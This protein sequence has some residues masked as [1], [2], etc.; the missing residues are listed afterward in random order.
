MNSNLDFSNLVTFTKQFW[1]CCNFEF[2]LKFWFVRTTYVTVANIYL[3]NFVSRNIVTITVNFVYYEQL[4]IPHK[5]AITLRNF[6]VIN[7]DWLFIID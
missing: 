3:R 5:Y 4:L 6:I 2:L 7:N 1:Y